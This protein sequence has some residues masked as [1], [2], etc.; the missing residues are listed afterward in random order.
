MN[1]ILLFNYI[2]DIPYRIPL[3]L[4]EKDDCCSG[5]HKGL[6]QI[7]ISQ[8]IESRYRVC[9]FLWSTINLPEK[10]ANIPHENYSTHVYLEVLIDNSRIDVDAT[11]DKWISSIFKIN[12]WDGKSN[13]TIAVPLL[14]K[15]SIEKSIKIMEDWTD[16]EIL[17]DLKINWKFYEA[18]NDWLE[19]NRNI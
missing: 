18:F 16:E 2:R 15:F 6:K 8:W 13:T 17:S 1:L 5:K 9:S 3:S 12:E 11:W 14:E 19:E 4:S 7:L 10:V